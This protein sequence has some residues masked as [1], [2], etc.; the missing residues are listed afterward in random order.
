MKS[1][2]AEAKGVVD[3]HVTRWPSASSMLE[4]S[5]DAKQYTMI[6]PDD[7]ALVWGTHTEIQKTISMEADG[8]DSLLDKKVIPPAD[9][10]SVD[11]Q[12]AEGL[13]LEG[14]SSMLEDVTVG[15]LCEVEFSELYRGQVLFDG[16]SARLRREHFRLCDVFNQQYF[17]AEPGHPSFQGRGFL[18]VGEALFL[19]ESKFWIGETKSPGGVQLQDVA[20]CLKLAAVAVAF[21]QLDYAMDICR[22]LEAQ[23]LVSLHEL[24]KTTDVKYI[25]LLSELLQAVDAQPLGPALELPEDQQLSQTQEGRLSGKDALLFLGVALQVATRAFVRRTTRKELTWGYPQVSKILHRYGFEQ[26]AIKHMIR[27]LNIRLLNGGFNTRRLDLLVD[28]YQSLASS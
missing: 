20:K 13:I 8:L 1:C 12:G 19:R 6:L 21:D 18:T 5:S 10:I 22:R 25:G 14:A 15:V 2:V 23:G 26:L 17:N 3:F 4:P 9:F 27:A 11:A 16:T 24:A 28:M 7:R